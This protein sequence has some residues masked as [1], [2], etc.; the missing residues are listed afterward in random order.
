[1]RRRRLEPV[2]LKTDVAIV[3]A[4]PAGLRAA[5]RLERQ[6]LEIAILHEGPSGGGNIY[7]RQ[8]PQFLRP[9][10]ALYA[11][12]AEKA[13]AI[14]RLYDRLAAAGRVRPETAVQGF[15]EDDLLATGPEGMLRV[16][17]RSVILAT[18]AVDRV[19]PV[20]GWTLPGAYTLGASQIA[21][22][23]QGVAVGRKVAFFGTGPLLYLVAWQYLK[24]G[25]RLAGVFDTAPWWSKA[26]Y[27]PWMLWG[28]RAL[29]HGLKYRR[30]LRRAGV[31]VVEGITPLAVLGTDRV[32]GFRYRCRRGRTRQIACDAL[33]F[34]YG[35]QPDAQ[36]A[37]LA[38]AR[39]EFN[40]LQA[41]WQV[42]DDGEGRIAPDVYAAG[43]GRAVAGAD[44]AEAA[45]RM[46][47]L[48][49][50]A[51]R[52]HDVDPLE[53]A[54][55]ARVLRRLQRFRRALDRAFPVPADIGPAVSEDVIMCRCE[56]VTAGEIRDAL[57][58]YDPADLNRLKALCRPGMGRCQGRICGAQVAM[59]MASETGRDRAQLGRFRGQMP[60]KPFSYGAAATAASPDLRAALA[61]NTPLAKAV[62]DD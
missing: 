43:D 35:V 60:I 54:G 59:L 45:G 40:R 16:S 20:P 48:S 25:V 28:G 37:E 29:L 21:L 3:G 1:M 26:L 58:C 19:L 33:G 23:H 4:G 11:S 56:A 2:T 17:A 44:A 36:L 10:E 32:S 8:P 62:N 52:G 61:P 38:G 46:A 13:K 39:F 41:V 51:D 7:R 22:K 47:A 27:A 57:R 30:D 50:L 24:A 34:G 14:H 55:I 18:G 5:E 53:Y 9:A 12:E 49:L 6:G 15:I 42:A 31:P